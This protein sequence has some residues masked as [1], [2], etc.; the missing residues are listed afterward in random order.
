MGCPFHFGKRHLSTDDKTQLDNEPNR[1]RFLKG[2]LGVAGGSLAYSGLGHA[3]QH[4][5]RQMEH[6]HEIAFNSE[7]MKQPFYGNHQSGIATAQQAHLTMVAFDVLASDRSS[8]IDLFKTLTERCEFLMQGGRVE[9]VDGQ[10]PPLDSGILGPQIH[11]DNLTITVSVGHSLFDHRFGLSHLKPI[12]LQPMREFPNDGLQPQWCHGD[13]LLQ[14]CANSPDTTLHALRDIIKHTPGT[15]A[16]RWRRDGFISTHTAESMGKR[17]PIN[18][19]GFRDGTVNPPASQPDVFDPVVWVSHSHGEPQWAVGGSYQVVRL[20]RFFV[21]H[22]D[23][24]PLQEQETIFGRQRDTGA[25]LGMHHE[26]DLPNYAADPKGEMI[27]LDAH[28]RLANPRAEDD[29]QFLL[30]RRGYSYS[31]NTSASGQ[32]DV[33]LIF[34]GYQANLL[35]GFIETQNRLNG[36]PLEEYIKPF[37][38]GYF[39]ALPG[40]LKKGHY[41]GQTLMASA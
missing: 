35:K 23:R 32:L 12:H 37:G 16:V 38:G 22:W 10:Y 17:T 15:L 40:V 41:L 20:I 36:E 3:A 7:L 30:L 25:P 5:T 33:G 9:Q 39:F 19:L 29:P 8:L 4:A 11:P 2:L 34:I 1:R 18:L 21:E 26:H 13:L 14:I 28:M 24:T 31:Y 27:P 6:T